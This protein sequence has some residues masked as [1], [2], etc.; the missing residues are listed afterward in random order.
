MVYNISTDIDM[1]AGNT[2]INGVVGDCTV[3]CVLDYEGGR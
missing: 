3:L 1:V 2:R